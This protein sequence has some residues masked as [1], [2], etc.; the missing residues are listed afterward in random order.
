MAE[1]VVHKLPASVSPTWMLGLLLASPPSFYVDAI[2]ALLIA[3]ALI[4]LGHRLLD[5]LRDYRDYRD[6]Y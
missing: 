4:R 6:G 1:F 5:L 3:S 2:V